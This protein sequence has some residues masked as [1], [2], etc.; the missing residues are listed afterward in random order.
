VGLK[1]VLDTNAVL[2]LLGGRLAE[3]L[4]PSEFFVSVISEIELLSYPSLDEA[5]LTQIRNLLSEVGVVD[6]TADVKQQAIHLRREHKVKVPDAIVAATAVAL[7]AQLLTNDLRLHGL[8]G[9]SCQR[10]QLRDM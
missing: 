1:S 10:L 3:P 7:G 8:P 2:Y 4:P 9:L 6:I 5:G